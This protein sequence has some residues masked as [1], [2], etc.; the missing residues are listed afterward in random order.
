MEPF[1]LAH[2]I[3]F[4]MWLGVVITEVLV[5]FAGS[6]VDAHRA[7]AVPSPGEHRTSARGRGPRQRQ[8]S[9]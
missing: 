9:L 2:L 5:E 8:K 4:G 6:D 3:V 1:H 7:A